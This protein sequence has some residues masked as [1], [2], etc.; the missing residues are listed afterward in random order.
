MKNLY[1]WKNIKNYKWRS[2]FL[3]HLIIM[4]SIM[5]IPILIVG[6]TFTLYNKYSVEKTMKS[7]VVQLAET[8]S[9]NFLQKQKIVDQIYNT[10]ISHQHFNNYFIPSP[11]ITEDEKLRSSLEFISLIKSHT[12]TLPELVG[13]HIYRVSDGYVLS[14]RSSAYIDK[15]FDNSWYEKYIQLGNADFE[16]RE[17][18]GT[19]FPLPAYT[20]VKNLYIDNTVYGVLVLKFNENTLFDEITAN[21]SDITQLVLNHKNGTSL[22][23]NTDISIPEDL[24]Y[25]TAVLSNSAVQYKMAFDNY[26]IFIETNNPA[27]N[28]VKLFTNLLM[29][30]LATLFVETLISSY[31][32]S[33]YNYKDIVRLLLLT[34]DDTE[35]ILNP[36]TR[37][38]I[39]HIS[40]SILNIQFKNKE[41]HEQLE[42]NLIKLRQSQLYTLQQ[43]INPHFIFN[44]L[45]MIATQAQIAQNKKTTT[46]KIVLL[47][48]EI[49]RFNFKNPNYMVK[50]S[51]EINYVKMYMDIQNI[52]YSNKFTFKTDIPEEIENTH[53]LK[54]MLQPLIENSIKLI[55]EDDVKN[56]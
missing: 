24:P 49:I 51:D 32:F 20:V 19:T 28:D 40:N 23:A 29:V 37:D 44:T 39:E 17:D 7:E 14:T 25:D 53:V 26:E 48:S 45:N 33:K 50:F 46:A 18:A 1:I 10:L 6:L 42:N 2:V 43:Q 41:Y 55:T 4:F 47:L 56:M 8:V 34:N 11:S 13:I 27:D 16:Y 38:E 12:G 35:Q 9:Y 15:F 22:I 5:M 31:I 54:F 36:D 30:I 21:V 3:R 52:R